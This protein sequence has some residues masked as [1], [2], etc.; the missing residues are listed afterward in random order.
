LDE[1]RTRKKSSAALLGQEERLDGLPAADLRA[2]ATSG[3]KAPAGT[4][5]VAISSEK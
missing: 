4:I 3:G 1:D 2:D 5:C